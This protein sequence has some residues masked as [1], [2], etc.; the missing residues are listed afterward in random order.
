MYYINCKYCGVNTEDVDVCLACRSELL[1]PCDHF[2]QKRFDSKGIP[3]PWCDLYDRRVSRKRKKGEVLNKWIC[4]NCPE[5][6]E[7][8]P[9]E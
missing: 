4:H 9:G 8:I 6:E 2:K 1:K 5:R 3:V 7:V